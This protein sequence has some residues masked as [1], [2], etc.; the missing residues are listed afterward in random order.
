MKRLI[1]TILICIAFAIN[2]QN[3]AYSDFYKANKDE[4]QF[5]MSVPVSLGGFLSDEEETEEFEE[6]MKKAEHCKIVI[7]N[8]ENNTTERNFKKFSRKKGLKTLMK[9]RD[10]KDKAG[11]FFIEKDDLVREI[12]IRANSDEEKMVMIGLKITLT[13][14]ELASVVTKISKDQ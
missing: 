2:A 8:N 3:T 6:L 14:D 7:F 9:V 12:I 4:S 13:K 11:I 5:S 1:T 10:G